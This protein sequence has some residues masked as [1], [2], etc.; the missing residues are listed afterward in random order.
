MEKELNQD[1]STSA[2]ILYPHRPPD[3]PELLVASLLL[4]QLVWQP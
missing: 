2:G 1:I 4:L 3:L